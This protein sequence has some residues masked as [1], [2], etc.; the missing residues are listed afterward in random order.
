MYSKEASCFSFLRVTLA[1]VADNSLAILTI[2]D[3]M[4]A[5][6]WRRLFLAAYTIWAKPGCCCCPA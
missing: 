2:P 4:L 3:R 1:A 6:H 5:I